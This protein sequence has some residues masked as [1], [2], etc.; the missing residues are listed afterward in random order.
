VHEFAIALVLA[1]VCALVVAVIEKFRGLEGLTFAILSCWLL[2]RRSRIRVSIS[3]ILK[4]NSGDRYLLARTTWRPEAFGPLGGVFHFHEAAER[5]LNA[6]DFSPVSTPA[7]KRDLRGFIVGARLPG[8]IRWFKSGRDR[9]TAEK[10]LL[11]EL[12]EELH[13]AGAPELIGRLDALRFRPVRNI[14]ELPRQV[15]G[16]DYLQFRIFEIFELDSTFTQAST[17]VVDALAAAHS[18]KDL[19]VATSGEIKKGT[20]FSLLRLDLRGDFAH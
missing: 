3:A 16:Q 17:F 7:N 14:Y 10:C 18:N 5:D 6:L 8:L 9:E 15:P 19:L 11:R 13:E 12:R 2:Q 20:R 4:L 1:V